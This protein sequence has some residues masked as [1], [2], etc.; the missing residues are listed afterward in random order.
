MQ[1]SGSESAPSAPGVVA[2]FLTFFGIS[3]MGFGGVLPWARWMVVEKRGWLTAAEFNEVLALCQFL[4]GGNIVNFGVV[5]GNKY[6]GPLGAIAAVSG[7]LI[8]PFFIVIGLAAMYVRF[9]DVPGVSGALA[10]VSAAAA[11]LMASTAVKMV[12]AM[13]GDVFPLLFA[14]CGFIAVGLFRL[15]LLAVVLVMAPITILYA[16]RRVQ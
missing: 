7:M 2:L 1:Q 5:L 11:G 14:A 6:Q 9:E 15:P 4:P 3:V 13:R 10:G 16:W 12:T 8:G